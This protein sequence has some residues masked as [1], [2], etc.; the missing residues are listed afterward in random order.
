MSAYEV[1]ASELFIFTFVGKK[2]NSNL[3]RYLRGRHQRRRCLYSDHD[4]WGTSKGVARRPGL[5]ATRT[6]ETKWL[7]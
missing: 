7:K 5:G 6:G 3:C 4:F 2:D 1:K